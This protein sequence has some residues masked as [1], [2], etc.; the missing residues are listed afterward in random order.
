MNVN[1]A[2]DLAVSEEGVQPDSSLDAFQSIE[3]EG[4]Q[5][6]IDHF[7]FQN[8]D[9]A[10]YLTAFPPD[11]WP[12]ELLKAIELGVFC[13]VRAT[14]SRDTDFVKHQA[15][16]VI[17]LVESRVGALPNQIRDE[18]AKR[19]GTGATATAQASE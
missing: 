14:A 16:R 8:A 11:Q 18:L 4:D 7:V 15:E 1:D 13:L 3:V 12:A 19:I 10:H 9:L 17:N 2:A 5:I 6:R